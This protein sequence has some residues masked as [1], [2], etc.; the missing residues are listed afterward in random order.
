MELTKNEKELLANAAPAARYW[1]I[2][3]LEKRKLSDTMKKNFVFLNLVEK[4][5]YQKWQQNCLAEMKRIKL[6]NTLPELFEFISRPDVSVVQALSAARKK[7]AKEQNKTKQKQIGK[8]LVMLQ[9]LA[10]SEK[11]LYQRAKEQF[12]KGNIAHAL[13]DVAK[14]IEQSDEATAENLL[15]LKQSI[16][17]YTRLTKLGI[18]P[19]IEE[20]KLC[21]RP[22]F[23]YNNDILTKQVKIVYSTY[24][25][26][27]DVPADIKDVCFAYIKASIE[28]AGYLHASLIDYIFKNDVISERAFKLFCDTETLIK[29]TG[30]SSLPHVYAG[31]LA[32]HKGLHDKPAS[33]LS[34]SDIRILR[35]EKLFA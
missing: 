29:R 22:E 34:D 14:Q 11:L 2:T 4:N 21:L 20:L 31:R 12:A 24:K 15:Y 19:S 5:I 35:I 33:E 27:H 25:P 8:M 16:K 3:Q 32:K 28:V 10:N 26:G 6:H 7:Y 9:R 18:T 1:L 13:E 30:M 17:H 23:A